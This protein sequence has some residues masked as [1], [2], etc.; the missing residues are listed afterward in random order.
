[1]N[2]SLA[3][4]AC[5]LVCQGIRAEVIDASAGQIIVCPANVPHKFENLGP[6]LLEQIDIHEAGRF[7]T[8]WLE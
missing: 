6:G 8:E 4:F 3:L 1:M 5:L 7:E 2:R